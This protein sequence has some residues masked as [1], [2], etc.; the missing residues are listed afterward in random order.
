MSEGDE[1]TYKVGYRKP[2]KETRF[3]PGVSGN[4]KGR[5]KRK[6]AV[7]DVIRDTLDRM[8]TRSDGSKAT[9]REHIVVKGVSEIAAGHVKQWPQVLA[10]LTQFDPKAKFEPSADDEE[11]LKQ[12]L[13]Q[14]KDMESDDDKS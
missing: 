14:V 11:R 10:W 3:R 13:S 8:V 1:E 2:P 6:G 12:L 5:K 7:V 4:P 9:I